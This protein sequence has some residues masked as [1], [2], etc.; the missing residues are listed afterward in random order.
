MWLQVKILI[1]VGYQA[2]LP[3]LPLHPFPAK[4]PAPSSLAAT[5]AWSATSLKAHKLSSYAGS[6]RSHAGSGSKKVAGAPAATRVPVA[7]ALAAAVAGTK[8]KDE[9]KDDQERAVENEKDELVDSFIVSAYAVL[10]DAMGAYLSKASS[11]SSSSYSSGYG[12][13]NGNV[14]HGQSSSSSSSQ[15]PA[16]VNGSLVLLRPG[17]PELLMEILLKAKYNVTLALS[18]VKLKGKFFFVICQVVNLYVSHLVRK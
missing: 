9:D 5:T 4:P 15:S 2:A 16:I 18:V 13:G 7:F 8:G 17:Y 6:T 12:N 1:G 3:P 11:S 14:G 10:R